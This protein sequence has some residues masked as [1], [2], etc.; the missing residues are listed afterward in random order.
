M[1]E[2][3]LV[4]P[5]F[6][7]IVFGILEVSRALMVQ[8]LLTNAARA[9]ARAGIIEGAS[10][11]TINSAVSSALTNMGISG[12][13]VTVEI[14]DNVADAS[15]ANPTDEITVLV[16]VPVSNISWLP[17]PLFLSGSITGKYTLRRE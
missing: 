9:G 4:V 10:N 12:D 6:I 5:V 14:N 16:S 13:T 7:T 11:T 15:T 3:A 8:H 17:V 2:F 1:V